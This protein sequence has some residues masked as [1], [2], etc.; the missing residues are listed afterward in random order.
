MKKFV[1]ILTCLLIFTS[2]SKK[3]TNSDVQ[4]SKQISKVAVV[5]VPF[6]DVL[7]T[8][9]KKTDLASVKKRYE[10]LPCSYIA[11]PRTVWQR[12]HQVVFHQTVLVKKEVG[13]EVYVEIPNLICKPSKLKSGE[14]LTGWMQKKDLVYLENLNSSATQYFPDKEGVLK[15][16]NQTLAFLKSPYY[17]KELGLTL[18]AT[19]HCTVA[20]RNYNSLLCYIYHPQKKRFFLTKIPKS[21]AQIPPSNKSQQL[22]L[23]FHLIHSWSHPKKGFVPYVLGG[24]SITTYQTGNFIKIPIRVGKHLIKTATGL[25]CY[26]FDRKFPTPY[27]SGLDCSTLIYL[28]ARCANLPYYS[29]NT[30]A[31]TTMLP[32]I[33]KNTPLK[34][35]DI[36]F[37]PGHVMIIS[38][39][40]PLK[41]IQSRAYASGHGKVTEDLAKDL[42]LTIK[43]AQDLKNAFLQKKPLIFKN[44]KGKR[45]SQYNFFEI[46][47]FVDSL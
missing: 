7:G 17:V 46:Y 34:K 31:V 26:Y 10:S 38:N 29:K 40:N 24:A 8:E 2:C 22:D 20:K 35:G 4:V 9:P 6:S 43:T 3:T 37:F 27:K 16:H 5:I 15:A 28:A 12:V 14:N 45:G 32:R 41:I 47:Q 44:S 36:I 11:N 13:H 18:S 1:T 42:F 25:P 21:I 23:F 19:T 39:L 30:T 33:T